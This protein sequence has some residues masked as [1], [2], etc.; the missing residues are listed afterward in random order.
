MLILIP[1]K[2]VAL[3]LGTVSALIL[4]GYFVSCWIEHKDPFQVGAMHVVRTKPTPHPTEPH[5]HAHKVAPASE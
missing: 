2:P 3:V 1:F 4:G 5:Q